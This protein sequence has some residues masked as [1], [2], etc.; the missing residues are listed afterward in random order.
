[1]I[2]ILIT[3][4][5][6]GGGVGGEYH[7]DSTYL[8]SHD[9]SHRVSCPYTYEQ[10]GFFKRHNHVIVEK[11]LTLLAHSFFPDT[12]WKYT[13]KTATYFHNHTIIIVLDF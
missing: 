2:K 13:F 11:G 10:N 9:I 5:G 7:N 8:N 3:I 12:F 1:M 6:G 4:W